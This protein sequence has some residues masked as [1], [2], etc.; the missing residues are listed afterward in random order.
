MWSVVVPDPAILASFYSEREILGYCNVLAATKVLGKSF[1]LYRYLHCR[2]DI[3]VLLPQRL[4][5]WKC[6]CASVRERPVYHGCV[7]LRKLEVAT[8][9]AFGSDLY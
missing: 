3:A 7:G 5:E 9:T 6:T 8:L 4:C 1:V 2:Q